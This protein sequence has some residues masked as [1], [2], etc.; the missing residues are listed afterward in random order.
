MSPCGKDVHKLVAL[1]LHTS[2]DV[3]EVDT[4]ISVVS[5]PKHQHFAN[6]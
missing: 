5:E 4:V 2:C 6:G 3:V 1:Q